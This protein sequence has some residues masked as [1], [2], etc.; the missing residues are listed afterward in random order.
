MAAA[1]QSSL[2]LTTISANMPNMRGLNT[3]IADIRACK[4]STL[5]DINCTESTC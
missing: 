4:L 2:R 1:I 5:S 3:F